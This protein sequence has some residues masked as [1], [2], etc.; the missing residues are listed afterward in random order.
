MKEAAA[1]HQGKGDG[2][3]E[4]IP[5]LMRGVVQRLVL[6]GALVSVALAGLPARAGADPIIDTEAQ[7]TLVAAKLAELNA[8]LTVLS[9][10]VD[11]AQHSLAVARTHADAGRKGL[12]SA[13]HALDQRRSS[14]SGFAVQAYISG[15][16]P[17]VTPIDDLDGVSTQAPVK[18]GFVKA[19]NEAREHLVDQASAAARVVAEQ[20]S[21][22]TAEEHSAE[23]AAAQLVSAQQATTAA[24]TQESDLQSKVD[25]K[26]AALIA[27]QALTGEGEPD[28]ATPAAAK[29][30]L[31]SAL[32]T[33]L[34][35]APNPRAAIAVL[36]ALS[37]VGD[38][39]VWGGAGPDMFDCS[40][41]VMWSWAQ[42]G[43]SLDH[44]TGDQINEGQP[45]A[46]NQLQPGDLI[47]MWPPGVVGG[48]PEHVTMYIGNNLIVQAPHVGAYVEVTTIGWWAGAARAAVR[49]PV[50]P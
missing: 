3:F 4:P 7:A 6:L 20:S 12:A 36:A 41:L 18:D 44:W 28:A 24:L 1:A 23:Q 16:G 45:I 35:P 8:Q 49:I 31:A 15:G 40:G 37:K 46:M 47:F 5:P 42:A 38:P 30:T 26:L 14:L 2:P 22:L 25:A 33:H 21:R 27:A 11:D 34:P 17:E 50:Q 9:G 48:P 29:A 43:V 13:R 32:L 19:V 10:K 39:Y